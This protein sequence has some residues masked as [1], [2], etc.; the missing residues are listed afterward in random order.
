MKGKLFQQ[1]A[2]VALSATLVIT[3]IPA[4][5]AADET[6]DKL[7]VSYDMLTGTLSVDV[8]LTA[9]GMKMVTVIMAPADMT[10]Y[11]PNKFDADSNVILRTVPTDVEGVAAFDIVTPETYA[12]RFDVTV[13]FNGIEKVMRIGDLPKSDADNL[14]HQF[15]G[16]NF[17]VSGPLAY[18]EATEQEKTDAQAYVQKNIATVTDGK[19]AVSTYLAGEAI[20][21]VISGKLSLSKA[22]SLYETNFPEYEA[23]V[24][25]YE[26]FNKLTSEVQTKM[27]ERFESNGT[28]DSFD[29]LYDMNKFM[30]M[31]ICTQNGADLMAL[32]ESRLKNSHPLI[33]QK[34]QTITNTVNKEKV[35]EGMW[36]D[37]STITDYESIATNFDKHIDIQKLQSING[38][39]SNLGG[40]NNGGGSFGT[41]GNTPAP[42]VPVAVFSDIANHWAKDSI[43]TMYTKGLVN[44]FEDGTFKPEQNVT[45]AEFA[46]MIVC[47]LGL[48]SNGDA[49]FTDVADGSWYNGYVA[50]AA[51]AGIVKGSDGKFNPNLY[52][53][54]QDA[55]VML[56]RV[57]EYKGVAMDTKA[58]D[59]ND[60]AKIAEYAKNSVNGMANLGIISGYN[61]GFAPVDNTTRAQAAAL[62]Q[63]VAD[64]IG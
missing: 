62:L 24:S 28:T 50:A 15:N 61:G 57:L 53:T 8:D 2:S 51:K 13:S 41:I 21:R 19:S 6:A 40:G 46:K 59:F 14:L 27:E 44:G 7:D 35:F 39:Q 30:S 45:R 55:A 63:R 29:K 58:I 49:D 18:A 43:E 56:A 3:G 42:V 54:R 48:D 36:D 12:G 22:L 20:S 37:R 34:Y 11:H 1:I 31:Y 23:G 47:L 60:S 52:I 33:Y 10:D 25:Y 5:F 64:R 9:K 16:G 4:V 32:S 26:D 17:V 38:S